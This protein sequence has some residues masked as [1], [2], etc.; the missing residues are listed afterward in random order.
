MGQNAEKRN[1]GDGIRN[2]GQN[3]YVTKD[4]V[5]TKLTPNNSPE[6]KSS[7]I[8]TT[9]LSQKQIDENISKIGAPSTE[10]AVNP[11]PPVANP[12]QT[13]ITP[14]LPS[15]INPTLNK[16]IEQPSIW[17]PIGG[18][19][20][21]TASIFSFGGKYAPGTGYQ[22]VLKSLGVG[23]KPDLSSSENAALMAAGIGGDVSGAIATGALKL[24]V[25]GWNAVRGIG[26]AAKDALLKVFPSLATKRVGASSLE[27]LGLSS[28]NKGFFTKAPA[29]TAA[30]KALVTAEQAAE[31][32]SKDIAKSLWATGAIG[33]GA[34]TGKDKG[35]V[36]PPTPTTPTE[37]PLPEVKP[38]Q[39]KPE[40]AAAPVVTPAGIFPEKKDTTDIDNQIDYFNKVLKS[41]SSTKQYAAAADALTNLYKAKYG[42]GEKHELTRLQLQAKQDATQVLREQGEQKLRDASYNKWQDRH[43]VYNA[44][45]KPVHDD[46]LAVLRSLEGNTTIPKHE[47]LTSTHD[48][49]EKQVNEMVTASWK[50]KPTID[51]LKQNKLDVTNP[52]QK[53]EI[54]RVLRKNAIKQLIKKRNTDLGVN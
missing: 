10:V 41:T 17:E 22:H 32:H 5:T 16:G 4:G 24:P 54:D 15:G 45:G 6:K 2:D 51:Y 50:H 11:T 52:K 9:P 12:T 21:D 39:T 36:P 8:E 38:E 26:G 25:L 31:M 34:P 48:E 27:Q 43:K 33:M 49:I 1:I 40:V 20:K 14:K 13:P 30:S 29:P 18:T 28:L 42:E 3:W 37:P 35:T 46:V 19:L 47:E 23:D 44:E 53:N 7:G